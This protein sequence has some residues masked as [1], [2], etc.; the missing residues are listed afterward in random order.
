MKLPTLSV[1]MLVVFLL[2][3]APTGQAHGSATSTTLDSSSALSSAAVSVSARP[4]VGYFTQWG[5][6]RRNYM[7]K[8]VHVSG[9]A[10]RLTH[11]NYAF[12]DV[13]A[14]LKCASADTFADYAKAF[15]TTES[16]DGVADPTSGPVLRGNFNQ[17]RKLKAM[18][19][20]LKVLISVGGWTLSDYFSNAALPQNRAAFVASCI[21]MYLKGNFSAD[22]RGY[23]G[24]FDGI[25][26]DWEY[27]GS[28]GETC[29]YRPE[30]TQN[31]TALLAEFRSQMN[32]LSAQTG[33]SYLLTVASP[34]G[35]AH[36]T[37]IE[38]SAIHQ[39][40]DF[41]N[42][43]TY[44]FHGTWETTTNLHSPLYGDPQDPSYSQRHWSDAAVQ[45]YLSAGVPA[46]KIH[47][48]VPFY[49]RGWS[50][51]APGPNGDGLYQAANGA[52]RGKYAAGVDDYK[53][54]VVLEGSY[55]KYFH[56]VSQSVYIYN[57]RT[58][59]TYD[60][61]ASMNNK[62]QY[63]KSKGLGGTMFWELSGDTASINL[64]SAIY[65]GLQ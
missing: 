15:D 7:V 40:L 25:D 63:I 59:W 33:R 58:W 32:A 19:P 48:G 17:L 3:L 65:T 14:T 13:S 10:Q 1:A 56:P 2:S 27:P 21:D 36:Y 45:A 4:I 24:I 41:I 53:E 29:N 9:S 5:I 12:A 60:D 54:L 47:L 22:L 64:L 57:G 26:I 50:G 31:Y 11:I 37:K 23:A 18:Y 61:P 55:R 52:A 38:L 6:Y 44:D 28:C 49:G 8:H 51:V 46:A 35:P 42:L 34:A 62:M 16:V 30:D 20:H 43:M 39:Y